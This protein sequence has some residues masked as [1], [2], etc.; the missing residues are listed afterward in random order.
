MESGPFGVICTVMDGP[1]RLPCQTVP[2]ALAGAAQLLALGIC[3]CC[4]IIHI[5]AEQTVMIEIT[6]DHNS[7]SAQ[8]SES[9]SLF[10]LHVDSR[11]HEYFFL[12]AVLQD[13]VKRS[14]VAGGSGG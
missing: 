3:S 2:S 8:T 13:L 4:Y 6:H 7:L 10:S 14:A 12:G 9:F 5:C 1:Y 11:E